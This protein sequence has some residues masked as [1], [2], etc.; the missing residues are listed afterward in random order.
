MKQ[1]F[2]VLLFMMSVFVFAGMPCATRVYAIQY[3]ITDLGTLGGPG[4]FAFGINDQGQVVGNSYMAF[5]GIRAF[6]YENGAMEEL[7]SF[8]SNGES[9]AWGINNLGQIV[10][11]LNDQPFLYENGVIAALGGDWVMHGKSMIRGR[12]REHWR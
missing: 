2:A 3:V 6:L 1:K 12:L 11:T 9:Y 8:G 5:G 10:G 7:D 4:S